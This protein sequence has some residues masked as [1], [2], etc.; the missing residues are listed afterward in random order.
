MS[1]EGEAI[2]T[3]TLPCDTHA[4]VQKQQ[5]G[6]FCFI[7]GKKNER[8]LGKSGMQ[9]HYLVS[10]YF[11]HTSEGAVLQILINHKPISCQMGTSYLHMETCWTCQEWLG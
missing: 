10:L 6:G 2:L 4:S 9:H 5:H 8:K 3:L 11:E 1:K 7:L